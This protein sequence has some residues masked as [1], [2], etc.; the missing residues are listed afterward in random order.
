MCGHFFC[1]RRHRAAAVGFE[2]KGHELKFAELL[3]EYGLHMIRCHLNHPIE[4]QVNGQ[5]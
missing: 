2:S 3:G 4:E 1:K 5:L